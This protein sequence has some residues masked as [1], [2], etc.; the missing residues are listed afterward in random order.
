MEGT[1][2]FRKFDNWFMEQPEQ[3]K[4]VVECAM[5]LMQPDIQQYDLWR[6]FTRQ[7]MNHYKCQILLHFGLVPEELDVHRVP[8]TDYSLFLAVMA[9]LYH[10]GMFVGK[11]KELAEALYAVFDMGV[12]K[13]T[14]VQTLSG[15][16]LEHE[17]VRKFFD[18][19]APYDFLLNK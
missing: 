16:Q 12:K 5:F 17:K 6:K 13:T 10:T 11:E 9:S 4:L 19:Y 14:V 1:L 7:F 15:R 18:E 8:V 2:S 3:Q